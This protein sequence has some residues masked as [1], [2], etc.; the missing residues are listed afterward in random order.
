MCVALWLLL[1]AAIPP[2]YSAQ[3][4][5][6]CNATRLHMFWYVECVPDGVRFTGS[7]GVIEPLGAATIA[8][9]AAP[10]PGAAPPDVMAGVRRN[11]YA[12][13][14][15][16][17]AFHECANGPHVPVT[18]DCWWFDSDHDHDVDQADFGW[19]QSLLGVR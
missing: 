3:N 12:D 6:L 13:A 5:A 15:D 16:V 14:G 11:F 8:S 18:P 17:L 7:S 1:A 9:W 19:L 4:Y 2:P 10:N